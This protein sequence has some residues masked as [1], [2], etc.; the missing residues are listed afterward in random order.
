[1]LI[2]RTSTP[3]TGW[4]G[5]AMVLGKLVVSGRPINLD[6]SRAMACW[7][8]SVCGWGLFGHFFSRLSFFFFTPARY[9]LKYCLKGSLSP[10]QLI[11]RY[12]KTNAWSDYVSPNTLLENVVWKKMCPRDKLSW[13]LKEKHTSYTLCC[14]ASMWPSHNLIWKKI[15]KNYPTIVT[16]PQPKLI[17][18]ALI[19]YS[20]TISSV[21]TLYNPF[22]RN[23]KI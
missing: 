14:G 1:M 10:K 20:Q 9:R 22:T 4:S 7:A 5:G 21:L 16:E 8:C 15:R 6:Y 19:K 3:D 13:A 18:A 11:T 17:S 2:H 12:M 23:S